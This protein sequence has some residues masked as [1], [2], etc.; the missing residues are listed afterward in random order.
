MASMEILI[1]LRSSHGWFRAGACVGENSG[2]E[3]PHNGFSALL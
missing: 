1:K 3:R 2:F